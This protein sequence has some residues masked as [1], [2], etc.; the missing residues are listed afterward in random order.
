MSERPRKGRARVVVERREY[1]GAV[2]LRDPEADIWICATCLASIPAGAVEC[3]DCL[4][5]R[6]AIRAAKLR[7]VNRKR[8]RLRADRQP[9]ELVELVLDN[10]GT[11]R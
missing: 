4:L 10:E 6:E 2:R 5:D 1:R 3:Y 11:H 7:I 9:G 8:A